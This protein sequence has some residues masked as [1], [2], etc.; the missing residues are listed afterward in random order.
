VKIQWLRGNFIS[1][2]LGYQAAATPIISHHP[3][4]VP[5]IVV[6]KYHL[7]GFQFFRF[8]SGFDS[9]SFHLASVIENMSL[10]NFTAYG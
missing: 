7:F 9:N 10:Y 1:R 6:A 5:V 4:A 8:F 2:T 3:S